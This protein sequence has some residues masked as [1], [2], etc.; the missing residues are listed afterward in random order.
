MKIISAVFTLFLLGSA[1]ASA[2]VKFGNLAEAK[3]LLNNKSKSVAQPGMR[4]EQSFSYDAG[5]PGQIVLTTTS[6]DAKGKSATWQTGF[7]LEHIYLNKI[8]PVSTTKELKLEVFAMNDQRLFR[9][10]RDSK[11]SYRSSFDIYFDDMQ[12]ARD[13]KEALVYIIKNSDYPR[14][15]FSSPAE[16]YSWLETSPDVTF[17]SN[18]ETYVNKVEVA[19]DQNNRISWEVA[20]T[21][22]KGAQ[23]QMKYDFYAADFN[24]YS[25]KITVAGNMLGVDFLTANN[26]KAVKYF[27]NG[28][29]KSFVN[30]F[31][32]FL[33]DPRLAMDVIKTLRYLISGKMEEEDIQRK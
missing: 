8:L 25:F 27:E 4:Y 30:R 12:A 24:I 14:L 7:F 6:V 33:D 21:D 17:T 22:A 28:I 13:A 11:S 5:K 20:V 31:V 32:I 19:R 3:E 2:Q 10:T 1:S 18:G 15:N 29:Q 26:A 23:K 16:A 9:E